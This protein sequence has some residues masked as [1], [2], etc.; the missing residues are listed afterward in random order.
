MLG[1][2][3]GVYPQTVHAT[4]LNEK[5]HRLASWEVG[6]NGAQ[7]IKDLCK[8]GEAVDLGGNGY[9]NRYVLTAAALRRARQHGVPKHDSPPVI[10]D[11]Y[12]L[13]SGWI[14]KVEL[15]RERLNGLAPQTLLAVEVWDQS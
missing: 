1:W 8:I 15:D 5:D 7:W 9:P 10:G 13:P 3:F 4:G 6:L 11:D 14:G 12:F 2:Y